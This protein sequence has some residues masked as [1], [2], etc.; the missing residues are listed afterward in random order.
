LARIGKATREY[1]I[2]AVFANNNL[3]ALVGPT[4][5]TSWSIAAV[6]GYPYITVPVGLRENTAMGMSFFGK[7]FTDG[8]LIRYAY[9]FEQRTKARITP[10][11]LPAAP[12]RSG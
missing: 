6:A 1:G 4:T 2:D 12:K 10:Q 9:A 3:D 11:L 7:P 8:P 5:G